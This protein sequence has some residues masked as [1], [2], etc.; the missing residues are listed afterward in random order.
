DTGCRCTK[1]E[2]IGNIYKDPELLE[3]K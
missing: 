3:S 1:A 2:V